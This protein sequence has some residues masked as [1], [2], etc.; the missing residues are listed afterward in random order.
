[1][2]L[3]LS[4][5]KEVVPA[6]LSSLGLVVTPPTYREWQDESVDKIG[7]P[8]YLDQHLQSPA[9]DRSRCKMRQNRKLE[10]KRVER[11]LDIS[12]RAEPTQVQPHRWNDNKKLKESSKERTT[13]A[14]CAV[15][16]MRDIILSRS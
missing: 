7:V 4:S 16:Q 8:N 3:W 11:R 14:A 5:A 1:M 12:N 10:T 6:T 13:Q 9:I 15:S 2:V